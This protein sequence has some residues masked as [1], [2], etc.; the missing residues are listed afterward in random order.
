MNKPKKITLATIK[1]FIRK[2]KDNLYLQQRTRF[3]GMVDCV[4]PVK[5]VSI[6]KINPLLIDF[7]ESHTYGIKN[8][9]FVGSSRDYFTQLTTGIKCNDFDNFTGYEVWNCVGSFFILTPIKWG[10]KTKWVDIIKKQ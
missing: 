7:N 8:A 3:D 9:W 4:L 6:S 1:S 5:D 2:N 10:I